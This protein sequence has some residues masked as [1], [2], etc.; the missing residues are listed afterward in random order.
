LCSIST[1]TTTITTNT[2]T[3][4]TATTATTVTTTTTIY[5]PDAADC[6]ETQDACTAAC[7]A[8]DTRNYVKTADAIKNGKV[9]AGASDCQGGEDACP[10]PTPAPIPAPTDPPATLA[11][12]DDEGETAAEAP[13]EAAPDA[14]DRTEAP[15]N[16]E[17]APD[18]GSGEGDGS[19][20]AALVPAMVAFAAAG[21]LAL[22]C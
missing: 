6:I 12:G 1:T 18:S 7:E 19:S 21:L 14:T 15:V 16:L 2:I 20:S 3:T 13:T 10:V 8:A 4:T 17:E 11:P 9:C 5:D 22:V